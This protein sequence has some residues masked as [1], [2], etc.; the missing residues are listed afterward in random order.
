MLAFGVT[1]FIILILQISFKDFLKVLTNA[2]IEYIL[3]GFLVGISATVFRTIRF[4]YF[5]PSQGRWISLY[6]AFALLRLLRYILPFSSGEIVYLNLLKKYKFS[7][8]IAETTPTWILIRISDVIALAI[9]F[10]IVLTFMPVNSL[11]YDK[12]YSFHRILGGL[13]VGLILFMLSLPL[14]IP[15]IKVKK[16]D[17]WFSKR[18]IDLKSGF[19]RTFGI[20]VFIRTI[21][22]SIVIWITNIG[23]SVFAQLAFNTP[24]KLPECFLASILVLCFTLLP[25]N[26]PLSVG[27]AEAVWTGVMVMAGINTS[28]A[29]SI[30]I[31]IR[32]VSMVVLM[33][34]GLI[35]FYLLIIKQKNLFSKYS[36]KDFFDFRKY[37]TE[38]NTK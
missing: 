27:T 24:L 15:H 1:I 23:L 34:D 18:L 19:K 36:V 38:N 14:W 9:W 31:S 30:A 21:I 33:M 11:I 37:N 6:G 25:I 29:I 7:P 12:L 32:I 13:S 10:F 28:Q 26:A 5:F 17:S 3:I 16:T 2:N 35:G 20:H 8:T 22:I 4:G